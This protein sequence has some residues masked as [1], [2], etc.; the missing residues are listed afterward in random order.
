[1]C[2]TDIHCWHRNTKDKNRNIKTNT[3]IKIVCINGCDCC[4]AS[5]LSMT[6]RGELLVMKEAREAKNYELKTIYLQLILA[7][8]DMIAIQCWRRKK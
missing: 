2:K 8:G 1:M 3:K 7:A 4:A 6:K 5:L